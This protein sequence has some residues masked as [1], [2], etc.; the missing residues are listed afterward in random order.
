MNNTA[1]LH[2]EALI[3]IALFFSLIALSIAAVNSLKEKAVK[4]NEM[5]A[6]ETKAVKCSCIA[7]SLFSN[8]G[9]RI[10]LKEY[11]YSEK[12]HEVK[13][14]FRGEE[15]EAF[16]IAKEVSSN[17]TGGKTILEVGVDEHYR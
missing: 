10:H 17:Q 12:E 15:K 9:G 5:L 4:G 3:C 14:V 11:C 7:D 16:S 8:S 2:L 13:A 6:A 1:Q